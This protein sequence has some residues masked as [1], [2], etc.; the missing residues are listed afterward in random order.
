[1]RDFRKLDVWH[2]G[3]NYCQ[4]IYQL[5]NNL[6]KDE[7]FGLVSQMNRA[8]ISISS[9]IAEGCSRKSNLDYAKFIEYSLGSAFELETQIII[10]TKVGYIDSLV[11]QRYLNRLNI[12]QRRLNAL[13]NSI[14]K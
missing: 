14:L 6:P 1:M 11:S 5:T 4:I 12:L 2:E 13:R 9:N 7:R 8:A 3:I 10:C